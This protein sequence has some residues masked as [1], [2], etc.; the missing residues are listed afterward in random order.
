MAGTKITVTKPLMLDETGQAIANALEQFNASIS[1]LQGP[2]GPTGSDGPEGAPGKDAKIAGA[3][4]TVTETEDGTASVEVQTSGDANVEGTTFQFAFKN[5]NAKIEAGSGININKSGDKITI[6]LDSDVSIPSNGGS[7]NGELNMNNNRIT[8]LDEPIDDSDAANK[9]YV[10]DTIDAKLGE[11][12]LSDSIVAGDGISIEPD[13][14]NVTVS[15][16]EDTLAKI[17]TVDNKQDRVNNIK[18]AIGA[19]E[20]TDGDTDRWIEG[21]APDG[22]GGADLQDI[23][24]YYYDLTATEVTA[25]DKVDIV[26]APKSLS[27]ASKCG[28]CPTNESLSG[29]IRVWA[30]Q[31][32]T[33][34]INIEYKISNGAA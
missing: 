15:I 19:T 22:D 26:I 1:S 27:V 2:A 9:K 5:I 31:V 14:G 33:A 25:N 10:D 16:D 34:S 3:T 12:D 11:L 28:M 17:N 13:E 24:P 29:K 7:I 20:G 6:G 21:T 4:A 32:P 23:Y 8:G 30:S 18:T